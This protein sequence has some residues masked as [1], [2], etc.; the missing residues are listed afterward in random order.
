[1]DSREIKALLPKVCWDGLEFQ[2]IEEIFAGLVFPWVDSHGGGG[3]S[4]FRELVLILRAIPSNIWSLQG[5]QNYFKECSRKKA[6]RHHMVGHE[7]LVF[8]LILR[9]QFVVIANLLG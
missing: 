8:L 3:G 1:M 9:F 5:K 4:D 2:I 6:C 7:E